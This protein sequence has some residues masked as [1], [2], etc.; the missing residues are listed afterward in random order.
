M[1]LAE[2]IERLADNRW[3]PQAEWH[4]LRA[5]AVEVRKLEAREEWSVWLRALCAFRARSGADSPRSRSEEEP[6]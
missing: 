4:K 1:T 2:R 3:V 5:I 6:R